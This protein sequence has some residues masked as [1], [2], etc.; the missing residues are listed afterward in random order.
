MKIGSIELKNGIALAPMAGVTDHA[1]RMICRRY[2]CEYSVSEMV[3]A[4]AIH[5]KDK[6]T[7]RLA[8]I[9]EDE[10]FDKAPLAIQIF[11]SEPEIMAEA[12]HL[13]E[14]GS[15]A[16]CESK[17]SP[18]AIDINAGCPVKKITSNGEGS[19]LMKSP[20]LLYRIV[21]AVREAVNIPLT[22]KIRAGWDK[23]SINALECAKA[24]EEGGADMICVHGRTKDQM[25]MPPIDLDVIKEVK[26][27]VSIPVMGNGG[28][29][30]V[31]DA[32]HMLEYTG[33]DGVM[34]AQG[35]MGNPFIFERIAA[36]IEGREERIISPEEKVSVMLEHLSSLIE[37]K[38]EVIGV[39]EARKHLGWY[40][41]GIRDSAL[42]RDL[43]NRATSYD[44][45]RSLIYEYIMKNETDCQ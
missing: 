41:A 22:V 30:T 4:K 16:Y 43:V 24:I 45:M 35:A 44:E 28:I 5:Y 15:Y 21:K 9:R 27:G 14:S 11:G 3:S 12:A 38:G 13:I 26:K 10:S 32:L 42:F 8:V 29:Y 23:S 39:C 20:D 34:I 40:S 6:K 37:E 1:F 19:A 7:S 36:R 33:C 31:D 18:A 17:S 25:Y 2:G